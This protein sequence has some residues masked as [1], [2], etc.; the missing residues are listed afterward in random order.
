M[1][2]AHANL[3]PV[4]GTVPPVGGCRP[5][6]G[7]CRDMGHGQ[8]DPAAYGLGR[9]EPPPVG[10]PGPHERDGGGHEPLPGPRCV[11]RYS[12]TQPA[13]NECGGG[14]TV[15]VR[16]SP[17]AGYYRS[18]HLG[19]AG[20]T[21]PPSNQRSSMSVDCH[22]FC[23]GMSHLRRN[24]AAIP[25]SPM[26]TLLLPRSP[27]GPSAHRCGVGNGC[28]GI[29]H[30]GGCYQ[31]SSFCCGDFGLVCPSLTGTAAACRAAPPPNPL[32]GGRICTGWFGSGR[33]TSTVP[34]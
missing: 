12:R 18:G 5:G 11:L 20:W 26:L 32:G 15:G 19:W 28:G 9:V 27:R 29:V 6:Q 13:R 16:W 24:A 33:R 7:S 23:N 4:L 21:I 31:R 1:L 22:G 10:H 14:S 34:W 2:P 30:V 8:A 3:G 17:T 25:E